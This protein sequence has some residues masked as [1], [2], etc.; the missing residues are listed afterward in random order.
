MKIYLL[1]IVFILVSCNGQKKASVKNSD[2]ISNPNTSLVLLLQDEYSG[3]EVEET[4][5]IKDQKGLK[6]FYS[7]INRTRKPG[8][9][10][11]VIDFSREMVI[12]Y[13][14]GEQNH[15]GLTKLNFSKENST[16]VMLDSQVEI[17]PIVS[18]N[19]VLNNPFCVYKM[20]LTTKNVVVEKQI[21]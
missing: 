15:S 16:Q 14:S 13:C 5:V 7:K 18:S 8:L 17:D 20:P 6:S 4:L 1:G 9:P 12:V 2:Q 10:V 3:F 19:T 21:K 11:P